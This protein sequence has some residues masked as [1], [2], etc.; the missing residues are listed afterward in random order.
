MLTTDWDMSFITRLAS[1]FNLSKVSCRF[2]L[3]RWFNMGN[4]CLPKGCI[5]VACDKT[6]DPPMDDYFLHN[7]PGCIARVWG[8]HHHT[9]PAPLTP[10]PNNTRLHCIP[11]NPSRQTTRH[12]DRTQGNGRTCVRITK[13][14]TRQKWFHGH[15]PAVLM[16]DGET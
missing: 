9:Y 14:N 3:F 5:P 11:P 2:F 1:P 13:K 15:A 12:L 4:V 8:S 6:N 10:F 16:M 7:R